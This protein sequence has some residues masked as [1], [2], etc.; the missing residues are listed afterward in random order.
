M[1]PRCPIRRITGFSLSFASGRLVRTAE[2]I[3]PFR[4]TDHK[5]GGMYSRLNRILYY[6]LLVFALVVHHHEW[7][8]AGA[9]ASATTYSGAAAVQAW[10]RIHL[11]KMILVL[12]CPP[13]TIRCYRSLQALRQRWRQRQRSYHR[14]SRSWPADGRPVDKLVPH[15]A[16]P[17]SPPNLDILGNHRL[18]GIL[19]CHYRGKADGVYLME[20]TRCWAHDMLEH[21]GAA[22]VQGFG[23]H[24][25]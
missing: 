17:A 5:T 7:L 8:V 24:H 3:I 25:A 21:C 6:L 14:N 23:L 4:H 16:S 1:T 10:V 13:G 18:R 11:L 9:L 22:Q 20:S 19:A 12:T 15:A 2:P